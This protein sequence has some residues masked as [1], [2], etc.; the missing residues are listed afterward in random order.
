VPPGPGSIGRRWVWLA[1]TAVLAAFFTWV[2]WLS[3]GTLAGVVLAEALRA[4]VTA[5]PRRPTP[6]DGE[7]QE[8]R[9][10]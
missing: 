8:P 10:G 1:F 5:A 6:P 4:A 3:P 2:G 7:Q 9:A